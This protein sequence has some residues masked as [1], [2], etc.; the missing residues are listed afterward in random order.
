VSLVR[1]HA[2]PADG[3]ALLTVRYLGE[4]FVEQL[5]TRARAAKPGTCAASGVSYDPGAIVYRPS[6]GN[7]RNR[8]QRMLAIEI[9]GK[10]KA[11]K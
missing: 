7:H 6:L 3:V 9:E 2:M 1:V 10:K 5:W 4:V 11:T 8:S